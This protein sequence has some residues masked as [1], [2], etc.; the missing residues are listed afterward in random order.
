MVRPASTADSS[1]DSDSTIADPREKA[2]IAREEVR[3][4]TRF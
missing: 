4:P 1:D 2:R 3:D